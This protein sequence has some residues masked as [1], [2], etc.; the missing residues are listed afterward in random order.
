M[1]VSINGSLSLRSKPNH[2]RWT[3]VASKANFK[4]LGLIE[5]TVILKEL[6]RNSVQILITTDLQYLVEHL[7]IE[8]RSVTYRV[9][10]DDMGLVEMGPCQPLKRSIWRDIYDAPDRDV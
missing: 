6:G 8:S 1:R 10:H 5:L 3:F 2:N 9:K 4:K 7:M